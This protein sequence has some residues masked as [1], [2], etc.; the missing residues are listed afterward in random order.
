M[1]TENIPHHQSNKSYLENIS[2]ENESHVGELMKQRLPQYIV[3]CFFTAGYDDLDVISTMNTG[4][5]NDNSISKI[6]NYIESL[7]DQN[8]ADDFMPPTLC[9]RPFKFPPGHREKIH[10]FVQ[11]IKLRAKTNKR[12][13]NK[14]SIH[15]LKRVQLGT[16]ED[17]GT[18]V[19]V[20]TVS[21][22]VRNSISTWI[23][24]LKNPE[25]QQL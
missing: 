10:K 15:N 23:H 7:I 16:Q 3:N 12:S 24:N 11:E 25:L 8:T 20:S 13:S 22:Q 14:E 2:V 17:Y 1:D 6:E 19:T 4:E 9:V 21:S 5:N 18:I